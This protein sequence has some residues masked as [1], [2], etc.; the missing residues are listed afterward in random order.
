MDDTVRPPPALV[1]PAGKLKVCAAPPP[2]LVDSPSGRM[3][4]RWD[5][6][7]ATR[8]AVAM[9]FDVAAGVTEVH[10]GRSEK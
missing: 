3:E 10:E 7:S 2:L 8:W 1:R 5:M 9:V 6:T 4:P